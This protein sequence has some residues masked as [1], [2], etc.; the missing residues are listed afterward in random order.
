MAKALID[1]YKKEELEEIVKQSQNL[2]EVSKLIGYTNNENDKIVKDRINKYNIDISHFSGKKGA[3]QTKRTFENVFCKD[4][5]ASQHTLREWF[6][7]NNYVNYE[8]SIC[9]NQGVWRDQPLTLILDHINGVNHDNRIENLRWVCPNCNQ[10]L[11]TTGYKK[12]RTINKEK[13]KYYCK[14]CGKE[15]SNG[16]T[17]CGICYSKHRRIVERPNREELKKLI[18]TTPFTQIGKQFGVSDNTIRKWCKVENLP[19]KVTEIKSY[20]DKEWEKI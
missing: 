5:I 10:Q 9:G 11:E 20:T 7:K 15:I 6:L 17:Y 14:D 16:A 19:Y 12:Y 2:R 18:R 4:S 13:I 3:T 1:N 8:C